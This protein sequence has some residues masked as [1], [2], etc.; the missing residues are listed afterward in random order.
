MVDSIQKFIVSGYA[1]VVAL[2]LVLVV[3]GLLL[4]Q[5]LWITQSEAEGSQA[6]SALINLVD[7][8]WFVRQGFSKS[9]VGGFNPDLPGVKT[10]EHFPIQLN[11]LFQIPSGNTVN[12]FTLMVRVD[13]DSHTVSQNL[14]LS[15]AQI[16]DNWAVYLNGA[17]IRR[18]IYLDPNGQIV[19]HRSMQNILISIPQTVTR[20]GLNTFVFHI[21]GN[22]PTNP[23]FAGWQVGFSMSNGYLLGVVDPL[24]RVRTL[25]DAFAW[26]QMGVYIFFGIL[27][28]LL[29]FRQKEIYSFYFG[30]FLFSCAIYSFSYSNVAFNVIRD[31]AVIYRMMFGAT[32]I[33]PGLVGITL[34]N[35]LYSGRPIQIGLALLTSLSLA[36]TLGVWIVPIVWI[37][38]LMAVFLPFVTGCAVYILQMII[39]AVRKKIRDARKI[40]IAAYFVFILVVWTGLDMFI[41]RTGVDLIGWTPFFLAFAFAL[42]F[43]E[44]LWKTTLELTET[45]RQLMVVRDTVEGQVILRTS[46]LC[47][48]NA[49]LEEKLAEI[50]ALQD[51]LREMTIRDALTGLFNRRFLDETLDR[52]FALTRRQ[53]IT[54]LVMVDIDHFKTL[55]DTYGHKAGDQV[56]KTLSNCMLAHFRQSDFIFRYGGEEFLIV[57]PGVQL[58]DALRRSNELCQ[59]IQQTQISFEDKELRITIS[60]GVAEMHL[61]D[62][63][64]DQSLKRA[65]AA[66]YIAKN[67]GR[68]RVEVENDSP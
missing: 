13:L 45:N 43:I 29:F 25:Q 18:E 63:T 64:P 7:Q 14:I 42:I 28:G 21:I 20:V 39:R 36:M 62:Q 54:S 56:L 2:T 31:T 1:I 52:E 9:D 22:A 30:I 27:Q 50:S 48:A 6:S 67:R 59:I 68:N 5:F 44:R 55:N 60:I 24:L 65:D 53:L 32:F 12:D 34:W 49:E 66:L 19:R 58:E 3:S 11:T 23:F 57:L 4:A 37:E 16:G 8:K 15:L 35:Y 40:L 26:L 38:T 61:T 17:E 47:T 10:V 51:S 33:W 46:Q 41:F